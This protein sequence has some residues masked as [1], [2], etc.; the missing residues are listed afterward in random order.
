[1][2][3]ISHLQRTGD[4][5]S[6]RLLFHSKLN[7]ASDFS[8][9]SVYLCLANEPLTLSYYIGERGRD[10][11]SKVASAILMSR[12]WRCCLC[13]LTFLSLPC[14]RQGHPNDG[15]SIYFKLTLEYEPKLPTWNPLLFSRVN[16]TRHGLPPNVTNMIFFWQ[17]I[18]PDEW[19]I[20]H[21]LIC[22][23]PWHGCC[24]SSDVHQRWAAIL[25][26]L[27][28]RACLEFPAEK[29]SRWFRRRRP[30]TAGRKVRKV[31]MNKGREVIKSCPSFINP[32]RRWQQRQIHNWRLFYKKLQ[33]FQPSRADFN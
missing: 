7:T 13:L 27:Q 19:I 18:Y 12:F 33:R 11:G 26:V 22:T 21:K 20:Q 4:C 5:T 30:R 23:F 9:D 24:D 3:S 31:L 14:L 29:E 15:A 17:L 1:M 25:Q 6:T 2:E 10:S 28:R 16:N 8:Y 32:P